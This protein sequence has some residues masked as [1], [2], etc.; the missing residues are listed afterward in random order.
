MKK[1][2]YA[3]MGEG[4][5]H[6]SRLMT[7][8]PKLNTD[9]LIIAGGDA[10][11]FLQR[12]ELTKHHEIIKVP[13][14]RF[15]YKNGKVDNWNTFLGNGKN[16]IDF[17]WGLLTDT[18][19]H[20]EKRIASY[21]PDLIVSDGEPFSQHM[22]S[23]VPLI[24]FDRF[25]KVA[26][27]ENKFKNS[28]KIG[29]QRAMTVWIYKQL[30]GRT[31]R[32]VTT[33]FYHAAPKSSY[34][35]KVISLGPILRDEVKLLEAEQQDHVVVYATNKYVYNKQL[36]ELLKGLKREVRVYSS[37]RNDSSHNIKFFHIEP[38][39]FIED[40]ATCAYA[41]TTPGNM[42]ISELN[43]LGKNALF[44]WTKPYE[45]RENVYHADNMGIGKRLD[46]TGYDPIQVESTISK[47]KRGKKVEEGTNKI[48]DLI[49]EYL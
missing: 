6:V 48:I 27:C 24:S 14:L 5:G 34:K 22:K 2:V 29:A 3:V 31:D 39:R 21:S 47:L 8:L 4:R 49:N 35:N 15:R 28:L 10:Y 41:I 30:L 13:T 37:G 1:L 45:Q 42:L 12:S 23:D 25:G 36:I 44:F 38:K 16:F 20:L 9:A 33:S 32:M 43:Y 46:A 26:F 17:K 11:D 19:S 7:I 18:I 40:V